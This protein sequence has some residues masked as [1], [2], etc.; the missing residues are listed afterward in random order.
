MKY[1]WIDLTS[2]QIYEWNLFYQSKSLIGTDNV[3][4][5]S[6]IIIKYILSDDIIYT[7][8]S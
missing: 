8:I 4:L 6:I 5:T 3:I 2:D 1:L 7:H